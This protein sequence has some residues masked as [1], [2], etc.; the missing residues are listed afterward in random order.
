MNIDPTLDRDREKVSTGV[1]HF[2]PRFVIGTEDYE[3]AREL[4]GR[5]SKRHSFFF[6]EHRR[7]VL[8]AQ[9]IYE[10]KLQHGDILHG[11]VLRGPSPDRL[12]KVGFS[13]ARVSRRVP[14]ARGEVE[15]SPDW[16][17][18]LTQMSWRVQVRHCGIHNITFLPT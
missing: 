5:N 9:H 14:R 3:K 11:R 12:R 2:Y 15:P 16:P 8:N 10:A 4:V 13:E 6:R 18:M 17:W 7:A 1:N